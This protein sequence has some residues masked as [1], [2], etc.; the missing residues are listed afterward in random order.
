M[1]KSWARVFGLLRSYVE[2]GPSSCLKDREGTY[3]TLRLVFVSVLAGVAARGCYSIAIGLAAF[4]AFDILIFNTAVVFRQSP[5]ENLFRSA[6]L[7]ML[8]YVS[9]AIAFA[10]AWIG[11]RFQEGTRPL[12]RLVSGIYQSVRTLTTAGPE[13]GPELCVGEKVLAS[14]EMFIGVYFL[15]IIIAGYLSRLNGGSTK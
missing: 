14:V 1:T 12:D 13:G 9:L 2:H 5:L 8:G 4:A 6:V 15:S 7:T 11:F 10:P 3:V